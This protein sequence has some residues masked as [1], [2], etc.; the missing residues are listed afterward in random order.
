MTGVFFN[1]Q[2]KFNRQVAAFINFLREEMEELREENQQLKNL[3]QVLE[4]RFSILEQKLD[5]SGGSKGK[6]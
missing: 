3:C 1:K 4:D 2:I 5:N 6:V